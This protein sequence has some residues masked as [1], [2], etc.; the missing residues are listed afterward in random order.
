MTHTDFYYSW[1][2]T[3]LCLVVSLCFVL[4]RVLAHIYINGA[5]VHVCNLYKYKPV[6][7]LASVASLVALIAGHIWMSFHFLSVGSMRIKEFPE[8]PIQIMVFK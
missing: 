5:N 8:R 4:L 3:V 2:S 7:M 1:Y 6:S